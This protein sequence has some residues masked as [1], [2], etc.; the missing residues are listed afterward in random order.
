MTT[1][2]ASLRDQRTLRQ[3]GSV[4]D[5]PPDFPRRIS[6]MYPDDGCYARAHLMTHKSYAKIP[7]MKLFIFGSL[8]AKTSNHP[9]GYVDWWYHVAPIV[10]IGDVMF[11]LDPAIEP[12]RPLTLDEWIDRCGGRSR[13]TGLSICSN[14]SYSPFSTCSG[15]SGRTSEDAAKST[16]E[17]T[18]LMAEYERQKR[19]KRQPSKVLGD[20]PPWA[21]TQFLQQQ[22][23]SSF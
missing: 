8:H 21:H 1:A 16:V 23:S 13:V 9:Q 7:M 17:G 15:S 4:S 3:R 19:L 12:E 20:Q 11:I 6:W 2:F 5:L 10:R 18:F 14:E 22:L